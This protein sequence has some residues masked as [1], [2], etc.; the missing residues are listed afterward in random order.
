MSDV[1]GKTG[2]VLR[3]TAVPVSYTHLDVYKRQEEGRRG[4]YRTDRHQGG[5]DHRQK[6]GGRHRPLH[7]GR[8]LPRRC[9]L[10][11]SLPLVPLI[12]GTLD[13]LYSLIEV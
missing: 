3:E 8:R 6:A 9:L 2:A 12:Y 13:T 1:K 7:A 5:P 11:T 4:L 10:Y